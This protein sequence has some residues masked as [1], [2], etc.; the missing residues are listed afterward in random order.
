MGDPGGGNDARGQTGLPGYLGDVGEVGAVL[1]LILPDGS[2]VL[3]QAIVD[4]LVAP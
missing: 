1:L 4:A 2:G 3:A